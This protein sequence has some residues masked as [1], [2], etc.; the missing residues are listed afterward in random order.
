MSHPQSS[1]AFGKG[2]G[3][4]KKLAVPMML[5]LLAAC[6]NALNTKVSRFN[7][8]PPPN[9]QT[10]AV[11]SDDPALTGGIEFG[12]YAR[13]VE[14]RLA[15]VG[16]RPVASPQ[17][18]DLVARLDYGVDKGR[19]RIRSTSTGFR[20]PFWSPW[21]GYGPRFGYGRRFGYGYGGFAG[22]W[23]YG[24][25]DPW[26]DNGIE[27]YTIYTSGVS[28]KIDRTAD[29][30][31]LFEGK[32]EAVSTSNRLPYLVPNLIEALFTGFP[33]NSGETV[34]ITVA[35]EKATPRR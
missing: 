10:I 6:T 7:D 9:G 1:R 15:S 14:E 21:Y 32:S 11:V 35:P 30:R 17:G 4:L 27:S 26:F 24:W 25:Q 23:G 29:G 3:L 31:R 18:A 34:R 5:A 28:L 2:S 16:Y 13:V 33:G 22:P 20:D 8:L 19:E 12:Q